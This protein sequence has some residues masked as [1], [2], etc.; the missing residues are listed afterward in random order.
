MTDGDRENEA[1]PWRNIARD[2]GEILGPR[3]PW[4]TV[5]GLALGLALLV[6]AAWGVDLEAVW[7]AMQRAHPV[8]T[9]L[10]LLTVLLTLAGKVARWHALFGES[11]DPRYRSLGRALVVGKL[12][13][14]LIPA[15]VGE[16]A[17]FYMLGSDEQMSRAT[18]MG[19][20]AAEKVFDLLFLVLAAGLTALVVPLPAW[21]TGSLA[22]AAGLGGAVFLTAMALPHPWVT[23]AARRL[24]SWLPDS[25][26]AWLTDFVEHAL[27]GLGSLRHPRLA[28]QACA[29]SVLAWSLMTATN[30]ALFRAFDLNLSVG[31]ALLVVTLINGVT[32]VPASPGDLGVFHS[33]T[34]LG[35][36]SLAHGGSSGIDRATALAYATVL[37]VVVYGPR[38]ALGAIALGLRPRPKGSES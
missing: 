20:I 15:R 35:L 3:R 21:L 24:G 36:Q 33:L 12:V 10:S 31:A 5:A 22:A 18:V 4:G 28:A 29:W 26:A 9:G 34:V 32:I 14:A 16:L 1:T 38:V 11:L 17:R 37:H 2:L 23:L 13:S 8:W 30:L 6:V 19:T 27:V 25:A 7:Q